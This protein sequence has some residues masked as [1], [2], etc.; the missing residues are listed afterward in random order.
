MEVEELDMVTI[1][2][3]MMGL[4]NGDSVGDHIPKNNQEGDNTPPQKPYTKPWETVK[5]KT[6]NVIKICNIYIGIELQFKDYTRLG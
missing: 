2:N 3:Q 1:Q 5:K 4:R 6:I